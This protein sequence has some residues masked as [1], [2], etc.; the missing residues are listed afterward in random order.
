MSVPL[1]LVAVLLHGLALISAAGAGSAHN[2]GNMGAFGVGAWFAVI[3]T[4]AAMVC[5]AAALRS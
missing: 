3:V 4:G 5:L 1:Y 2:A